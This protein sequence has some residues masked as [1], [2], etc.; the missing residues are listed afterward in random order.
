M[1]S[2]DSSLAAQEKPLLVPAS[3]Q[4]YFLELCASQEVSSE[5]FS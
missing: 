5:I 2:A 4:G 3:K 1:A